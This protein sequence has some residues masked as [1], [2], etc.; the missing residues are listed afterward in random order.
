[1]ILKV[2]KHI[3]TLLKDTAESL[4]MEKIIAKGNGL[5][6]MTTYNLTWTH[7]NQAHYFCNLPRPVCEWRL[8]GHAK[9]LRENMS[10][11]LYLSKM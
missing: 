6:D 8:N 1:M 4:F 9:S 7:E 3:S 5:S 10:F 11:H 2:F